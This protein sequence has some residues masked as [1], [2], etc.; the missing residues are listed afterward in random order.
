MDTT[1]QNNNV[2]A[3]KK[4]QQESEIQTSLESETLQTQHI[5]R[6]MAGFV[7]AAILI[8]ALYLGRDILL[9]LALAILLAFLLSPLVAKL[10]RCGLPQWASIGLVMTMTLALLGGA[11]SYLG[12][13]LSSL[14]QELPKYQDTIQQ[15][16][17]NIQAY[18]DG[19]S[20]WDGAI[21]TYNTVENSFE[22]KTAVD[23]E[24]NVQNVKVVGQE[25]STQEEVLSWFNAVLNPLAMTGIVFLFVILILI[26]GKDLHDRFLKLLGGNLNIGTEV[27][28]D[29]AKSIGTYLRMQLLVN[30]TYGIPMAMGLWLIGVPAAI[31]WG[32]VAIGMRFVPYIGPMVSAIFPLTLAFAVDPTWNMVLWTLGLIIV[33]ELIS[34]NVIEPW[35]YGESTGLSTLAIILAAT[36]WTTIWGAVG[37]MLSTP[38]T[39]CLLV[40]ANYIPALG[41]LKTLIGNAAV[42]SPPERFYQRLVADDV[43]DAMQVA[44][45]Y[46]EEGVTKKSS[47]DF[48]VRRIFS[49]YEDVAIPAIRLFSHGHNTELTAEHRLRMHQGLK[50]FNHAF[51]KKY[52]VA[53]WGLKTVDLAP[54]KVACL[55]ARWE[56]DVQISTMLAHALQLKEIDAHSD[57]HVLIQSGQDV[58]AHVEKDIDIL[59]ISLFHQAPAAQIRLLQH[60]VQQLFPEAYVIFAL[61]GCEDVTMLDEL[62]AQFELDAAVHDLNT[63]L[64][65]IEAYRLQGQSWLDNMNIEHEDERIEALNELIPLDQEN[66]PIYQRYI[67]EARQAFDVKYAQISWLYPD[68][69]HTPMSAL[70][71]DL[72]T[73]AA[74]QLQQPRGD[75][76][77]THLVHQNDVLMIEDLQRDP[78][79]NQLKE[80]SQN[81]IR[82][83]AGV[84]LRNKAGIVLGSLCILD[85]QP[86]AMQE[87]DIELLNALA[88]DLMQTLTHE[89]KKK[90]K[91]QQIEESQAETQRPHKQE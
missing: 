71:E 3:P 81:K 20:V 14:S 65:T 86:R 72:E 60:T 76:I 10:K 85:K 37:L 35:L 8:A 31:M 59:C 79:F 32:M 80:L 56:I 34:N 4:P 21:R 18:S 39:A 75:A 26:N 53:T 24:A 38:L 44:N 82:F 61:W 90:Q 9:P 67:E 22:E 88:D 78:R 25:P 1:P 40:L 69:V 5:L 54:I 51:Q 29:A 77:C 30:A 47:D 6:V 45:D 15:K 91:Q 7:I 62:K 66:A 74:M 12:V 13:Q 48:K 58:L 23:S 52:A 11:V 87:G 50:Y 17:E 55:G 36:F 27:L 57:S 68:V 64:L 84:P 46:I 43:D 42:L 83:Y 33:L 41:F 89:G 49:F 19:P 70:A 16:I 73:D 2:A 28:D 63:L